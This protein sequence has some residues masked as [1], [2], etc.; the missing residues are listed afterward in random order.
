MKNIFSLRDLG[1]GWLTLFSPMN[2][3]THYC[4]ESK[5]LLSYTAQFY[6]L[7]PLYCTREKKKE[8]ERNNSST[9]KFKQKKKKKKKNPSNKI[10]TNN[11]T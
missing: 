1:G 5:N 2:V 9:N 8:T 10:K 7:F 4:G 3:G 11:I 6:I